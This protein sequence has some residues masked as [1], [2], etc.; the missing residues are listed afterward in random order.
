MHS[1][2]QILT[3]CNFVFKAPAPVVVSASPPWSAG[4]NVTQA[5][6]PR[7]V[8][9]MPKMHATPGEPVPVPAPAQEPMPEP[10]APRT[11]A[12]LADKPVLDYTKIH[13]PAARGLYAL[14][15]KPAPD[16]VAEAVVM[17]ALVGAP[18]DEPSSWHQAMA[19]PN[20]DAWR[21]AS[22]EEIAQLTKCGMFEKRLLPPG[23]KA[24]M[25][26]WVLKN[27]LD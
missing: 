12:R 11:S 26:T 25:C 22:D 16:A 19:G 1:G 24:I 20:T 2:Q 10:V 5:S 6:P 21:G 17:A 7:D 8:T 23:C 9:V 13:N 3:T 18:L 27:K 15:T 14:R 4:E